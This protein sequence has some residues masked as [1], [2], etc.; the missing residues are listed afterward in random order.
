[1][2]L[3][4]KLNALGDSIRAKAGLTELLTLDERV[5]VVDSIESNPPLP[6]AEEEEF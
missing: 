3:I 4:N 2:A 5:E 1:M 6:P